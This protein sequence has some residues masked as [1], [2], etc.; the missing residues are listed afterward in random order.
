MPTYRTISIGALTPGSVLMTPAFDEHLIKLLDAGAVVDQHLIDRLQSLGITE[1]VVER[2]VKKTAHRPATMSPE[3]I[4]VEPQDA[5]EEVRRAG[6]CGVCG[7]K[8][9]LQP[10]TLDSKAFT[11][12]CESCG[13]VYFGSD[14]GGMVPQGIRRNE[15]GVVNPFMAPVALKVEAPPIPLENIQRIVKSLASNE[16]PG[17]ERR[18][19]KRHPVMVP[20]VAL[21]LAADFHVDGEPVKMTTAN[22]S[23]GGAALIHT[24]FVDAPYLAMDFTVAG[25]ELWQVVFKVLRVQSR[26][27]VY[28][29]GGEFVSRLSRT[30]WLTDRT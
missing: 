20:V 22:V 29:V 25:I 17:A 24:R 28:E 11:W 3:T 10:P 16:Q 27:I 1:V 19:H 8:I 23:L 12:L 4:Q 13:T 6:H 5:V 18:R 21:P 14:D 7:S 26:G 2:P 15:L 30:P 9:S